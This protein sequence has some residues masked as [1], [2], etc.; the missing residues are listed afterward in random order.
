MATFRNFVRATIAALGLAVLGQSPPALAHQ[1]I[2]GYNLSFDVD[3][4]PADP[5]NPA[6][7]PSLTNIVLIAAYSIP[8]ESGAY[9]IDWSG[10]DG[11]PLGLAPSTTGQTLDFPHQDL[12]ANWLDSLGYVVGV[13][14]A[15]PTNVG[16]LADYADSNGDWHVVVGMNPT[17][18]A[19]TAGQSFDDVVGGAGFDE[20]QLDAEL[21]ELNRFGQNTTGCTEDCDTALEQIFLFTYYGLQFAEGGTLDG[22]PTATGAF[23]LVSFSDGEIVGTVTPD[24][25][26]I[27][28]DTSAP[29][30]EPSTWAM[31]LLG[32]AGLGY[33]GYR[34]ARAAA[35]PPV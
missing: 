6:G 32:F 30:P 2:V 14:G 33:A 23:D 11:G 12:L 4:A 13:P 15:V 35:V 34:R 1:A 8:G 26:P 29:V 19:A 25:V 9:F 22:F 16:F 17:V 28:G 3:Y 21:Q 5:S 31:M 24:L 20:D 10:A 7:T 27:F 18:A